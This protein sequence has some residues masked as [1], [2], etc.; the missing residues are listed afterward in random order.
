VYEKIETNGNHL[1]NELIN[2]KS[3]I[4][5]FI[6]TEKELFTTSKNQIEN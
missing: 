1:D 5:N 2:I 3:D 6:N 4:N